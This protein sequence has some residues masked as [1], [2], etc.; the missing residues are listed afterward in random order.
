MAAW[1]TPAMPQ[2][3]ELD[4]MAVDDADGSSLG[5]LAP[6]EWLTV[7]EV[8]R[9]VLAPT[10]IDTWRF[11]HWD[12]HTEPGRVFRDPWGR[13]QNPIGFVLLEPTVA[14]A[15][16]LPSDRDIDFDTVPDWY[17]TGLYGSV[18]N[19]PDFDGDG[20]GVPLV[21]EYNAGTHPLYADSS[22]PGGLHRVSGEIVTLNIAGYPH[23]ALRSEPAGTLDIAA[24]VPTGTLVVSPSMTLESFGYWLLDGV[25]QTDPW[26]VAI[27]QVQF[28]MA[29]ANREGVAYLFTS[30]TDVDAV[31]DA[32]EHYYFG[33]LS[34]LGS[35]DADGDNIALSNEYASATHPLFAN[36]NVPGG[37]TRNQGSTI[38]LNIAGYPH[39]SLISEPTGAVDVAAFVPT[40]TV[41]TSPLMDQES[42]GYWLLDGLRQ[43]DE[44]GVSLRQ[45]E[46]SM[47]DT[48]REG[49]AYMFEGDTDGDGIS[50]AAELYFY[51]GLT[52]DASSDTDGDAVSLSNEIASVTHPLFANTSVPGG[53]TRNQGFTIT[54]NIAGYPHYRLISEP[55]GAV[56]VAAFVPTGAVVTSPLM[57]QESFGYWLLDGLRQSDEWGV[58]L[59]QLEFSMG[60]TDR[61][62]VAYMFEGDTDGDG[63]S[64]AAELYFYGGLTNDASSDTDGDA[65]SLSNEIASVTHPLF[66]NT[67]V[68]GG[69][70]R[71]N[72]EGVVIN[73][74][75]FPPVTGVLVDGH[76]S[77]FFSD[78]PSSNGTFSVAA[79]SHPALGD[80][81]GDGDL[82]LFVGGSPGRMRAYENQ[83]SPVAMN[84]VEQTTNFALL[85]TCWNTTSNPAPAL[86][87][88]NRDGLA[89]LAVGGGTTGVW[90]AASSGSWASPTG[91]C[92]LLGASGVPAFADSNGDDLPDLILLK[93]D[94]TVSLHT[95]AAPHSPPFSDTP[96]RASI[97]PVSVPGGRGIAAADV[98][99]DGVLDILVSD[100]QG[101]IW[102]FH[103]E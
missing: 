43:S 5:D 11:T 101:R 88:W 40:G 34:Q 53:I 57:D 27:R 86:A 81:D 72:S 56:D 37:I 18:S 80:W 61:E 64:D 54:L 94:G 36:T 100:D 63:I 102:E 47:G 103:G 96:S 13:A 75:S 60:D 84:L 89:D 3:A 9:S 7:G 91:S 24:F 67:N 25:R 33:D 6:R 62:G 52:N 20:D 95:N 44:W 4:Q 23:Y 83:G 42:F 28:V 93:P 45:L 51:G 15:H 79:N 69:I 21:E 66:A 71:R 82:D 22:G 17:E 65:V 73:L 14:V 98:N 59:R 46:F 26:G 10:E 16:Y 32:F 90:L 55:T 87:D 19:S 12:L 48:D 38:T 58:S 50:D 2:V 70:S 35:S 74:Q 41:V 39:Y 31:P 30:D 92:W 97:L 1:A 78:L 29:D 49:V 68:P 76:L 99:D 85:A 8:H 77:S